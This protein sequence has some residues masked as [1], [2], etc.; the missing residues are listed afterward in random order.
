MDSAEI[1]LSE[2]DNSVKLRISTL[3]AGIDSWALAMLSSN[4]DAAA[5]AVR[6][7]EEIEDNTNND[8]MNQ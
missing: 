4:P 8:Y 2:M 1:M 6:M 5:A 3:C 7:M